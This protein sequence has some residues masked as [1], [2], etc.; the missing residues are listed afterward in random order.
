MTKNARKLMLAAVPRRPG[1][2]VQAYHLRVAEETG[3]GHSSIVHAWGGYYCSARTYST[4]EQVANNDDKLPARLE[5]LARA[6]DEIAATADRLGRPRELV[7][8]LRSLAL[9]ARSFYCETVKQDG[10]RMKVIFAAIAVA[11]SLLVAMPHATAQYYPNDGVRWPP[12]PGGGGGPR[13]R[14]P[15]P[16]PPPQPRPPYWGGY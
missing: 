1:E 4:L 9:E 6:A 3:L 7:G 5:E 16:P 15:Q 2:S 10:R 14:P 13:P 11:T 12:R 8:G